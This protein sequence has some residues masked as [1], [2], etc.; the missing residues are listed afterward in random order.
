[1]DLHDVH[2]VRHHDV[3][4]GRRGRAR[5]GVGGGVRQIGEREGAG[6]GD[7]AALEDAVA[8]ARGR[9]ADAVEALAGRGSAP[10]LV[11]LVQ[12]DGVL[13]EGG[14]PGV[15]LDGH[16]AMVPPER[17]RWLQGR[18]RCSVAP[19]MRAFFPLIASAPLVLCAAA[20]G[21]SAT[22]PPHGSGGSSASSTS[23][24]STSAS[25][26]GTGGS[27]P[28]DAPTLVMTKDGPVQ[29]MVTGSTR[30][31]FAIPFA[32]PPTGDLRW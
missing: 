23:A 17:A 13:G 14:G 28:M 20:C 22:T 26:T 12:G 27:M 5:E 30:T 19:A 15:G 2:A 29:G 4:D 8:E 11:E 21:S 18:A 3:R 16:G 31:F 25:S 24:S 32:A 1:R 9:A 7:A 10:R 6:G